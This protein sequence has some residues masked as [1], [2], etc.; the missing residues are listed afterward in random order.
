MDNN[1]ISFTDVLVLVLLFYII[2][3]AIDALDG[4]QKTYQIYDFAEN[5]PFLK[6]ADVHT[7]HQ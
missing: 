5:G 2:T 7:K 1:Y 3:K 6:C 4:I